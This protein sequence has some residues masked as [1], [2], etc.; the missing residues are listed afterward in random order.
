MP[1]RWHEAGDLAAVQMGKHGVAPRRHRA[2]FD[3][4]ACAAPKV[5]KGTH[6]RAQ[7]ACCIG[8]TPS[9]AAA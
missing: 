4:F 1:D 5:I 3:T 6:K 7:S 2:V 9:P 8:K